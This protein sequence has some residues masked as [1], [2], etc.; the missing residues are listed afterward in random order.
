MPHFCG[1]RRWSAR[2]VIWGKPNIG[3][4]NDKR[5][6]DDRLPALLLEPR[7]QSKTALDSHER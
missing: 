5:E 3:G 2:Y 7:E 4:T 6:A 1:R